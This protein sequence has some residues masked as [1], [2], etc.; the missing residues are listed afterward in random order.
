LLGAAK[1]TARGERTCSDCG[2][3]VLFDFYWPSNPAAYYTKFGNNY[4]LGE[5]QDVWYWN[6]TFSAGTNYIRAIGTITSVSIY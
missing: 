6:N 4:I 2:D 3:K 1:L 5:Y